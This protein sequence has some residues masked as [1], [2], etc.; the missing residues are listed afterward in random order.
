VDLAEGTSPRESVLKIEKDFLDPA[1]KLNE[2]LPNQ[3]HYSKAVVNL[4]LCNLFYTWSGEDT[5]TKQIFEYTI[6]AYCYKWPCFY[7]RKSIIFV[8]NKYFSPPSKCIP[9]R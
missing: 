8:Q 6:L 7:V 9:H 5:E 3:Y 4:I 2:L 1:A